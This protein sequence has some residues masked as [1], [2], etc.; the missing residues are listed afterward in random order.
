MIKK[1]IKIIKTYRSMHADN[2]VY[3]FFLFLSALFTS[4][5]K[6]TLP[7]LAS[8]IVTYATDKRYET[9]FYTILLFAVIY[10]LYYFSVHMNYVMYEKHA[11]YTHNKLQEKIVNK[12]EQ[13]D[14]NYSKKISQSFLVNTAFSD[15]GE[16]MQ[17]PDEFFDSMSYLTIVIISL[18]IIVKTNLYIGIFTILTVIIYLLFLNKDMD[19]RDYYLTNET[20][21]KDKASS[22]IGQVFDGN[23]EVRTFH[24]N[25][26]LNKHLE[27]INK[28]WAKNHRKK[29]KY[30]NYAEIL[31]PMI[32]MTF[33]LIIY[34][35]VILLIIKG[36]S[37]VGVLVLLISYID[38]IITNCYELFDRLDCISKNK[39]RLNRVHRILNYTN[40]HMLTFGENKTDDIFG[41]VIFDKVSFEYEDKLI[42]KNVSFSIKANSCTAIVGKSG[43]GKSTIFRILLRLY[44]IKK[45]AVYIDGINIYDYSKDVYSKNVSIVTQKPFMFDMSI[46]ENFNLV[47]SNFKNQVKAC[48]RVGI[49]DFIMRLP[50]GYNTKLDKDA[51]NISLGQKQL[52]ALART[53]LSKAEI[54]LFDEVTA[55]LDEKSSQKIM[56]ILKDLKKD[57]TVIMITHKPNLMK[58]ADTILVID[59]GKVEAIGK[60]K[61]LMEESSVYRQLQK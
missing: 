49:H 34:I 58:K 47:D 37:S 9:M 35:V 1:Y 31:D 30:V 28:N 8:L 11:T 42:L 10:F 21:Y 25:N 53:L 33:K 20:I 50:N 60:H 45:G 12:V 24:M 39:V 52:I 13:M 43:S 26:G 59:K 61:Y 57:H 51:I 38:T 4:I 6:G 41:D 22:L 5:F 54:L 27:D 7:F 16:V 55:S 14:G 18:V 48:K 17:I 56:S 36:K 44:K 23:K 29:M 2:K 3:I 15:V 46:R 32:I 40:K 19:K